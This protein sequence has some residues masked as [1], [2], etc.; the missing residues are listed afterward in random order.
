MQSG[1]L[2]VVLVGNDAH[3]FA[4][5]SCV[6]CGLL[7]GGDLE[8]ARLSSRGDVLGEHCGLKLDKTTSAP[9]FLPVVPEVSD[10]MMQRVHSI[11]ASLSGS[12]LST[13]CT[14]T[15]VEKGNETGE[16]C[17]QHLWLLHTGSKQDDGPKPIVKHPVV[18][19]GTEVY[20]DWPSSHSA[21]AVYALA[22]WL[23]GCFCHG[24]G[25]HAEFGAPSSEIAAMAM[26]IP[27]EAASNLE[28]VKPL[29]AK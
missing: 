16:K 3:I 20:R 29:P 10:V 1:Q 8:L 11:G 2:H 13:L 14:G 17:L 4:D 19:R 7:Q 25:R 15:H 5:D 6:G 9:H 23:R 26:P 21:E 12:N 18:L 22:S 27:K 24:S 28:P